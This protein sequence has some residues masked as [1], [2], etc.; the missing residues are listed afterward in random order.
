MPSRTL[1]ASLLLGLAVAFAPAARA[2][3]MT[4]FQASG[5]L[6]YELAGLASP[7]PPV[8]GNLTL[9]SI[10]AGAVIQQVFVYTNDFVS[11]GGQ[12][13]IT[14]T[15]PSG[16]AVG[17]TNVSPS[18]SDPVP[19]AQTFGY[20]LQI[21]PTSV[22]G[23]GSYGVHIQASAMGGNANQIAGLGML[24]IYSH[25][26]LSQSTI[27][28]NDGVF[29]MTGTSATPGSNATTFQQQGETI[30]ASSSAQLSILT[31]ADD[32]AT[33]GE[34]I[35]FNGAVVGGPLDANLP[36]GGSASVHNIAVTSTAGSTNTVGVTSTGDIFGWHVAVLQTPV[37]EPGAALTLGM[38]L[39]AAAARARRQRR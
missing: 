21:P 8:M 1:P 3:M 9:A 36:G 28:V 18:S 10:P 26:L 19:I 2:G 16:P 23:N 24:V 20:K 34:Q 39:L 12:L 25:P 7:G 15:P 17:A 29:F 13:D 11:G 30:H 22:L 4:S 32:P 5:Q 35:L 6:G 33:S 14:I 37:P 31:F 38:G 27:T